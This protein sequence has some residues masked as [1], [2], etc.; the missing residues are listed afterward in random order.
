MLPSVV[1]VVV[2]LHDYVS[3]ILYLTITVRHYI[4]TRNYT[5]LYHFSY[6]PVEKG[7]CTDG[8]T[9]VCALRLLFFVFC[10]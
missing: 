7:G 4:Y 9:K 8:L 2:G 3:I 6:F 1:V 10:G 5:T